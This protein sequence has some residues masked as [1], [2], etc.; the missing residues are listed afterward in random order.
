MLRSGHP[1]PSHHQAEQPFYYNSPP[2][3]E[4]WLFSQKN[5]IP[6]AGT[7][8]YINRGTCSLSTPDI[9]TVSNAWSTVTAWMVGEGL[10]SDHLPITI[11]IRREV[12]VTSASHRRARWKTINFNWQHVSAAVK[13]AVDIFT[14]GPIS[15]CDRAVASTPLFSQQQNVMLENSR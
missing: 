13:E 4:N 11:A 10:D 2:L 5:S 14:P 1:L 8:T 15:I 3:V 7:G 9:T 12:P 6:N